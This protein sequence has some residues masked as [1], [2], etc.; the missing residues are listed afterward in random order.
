MLVAQ[1]SIDSPVLAASRSINL[2]LTPQCCKNQRVVSTPRCLQEKRVYHHTFSASQALWSHDSLMIVT[3]G[4][5]DSMPHIEIVAISLIQFKNWYTVPDRIPL[6]G[7]CR[8][9]SNVERRKSGQLVLLCQ[10]SYTIASKFK[11]TQHYIVK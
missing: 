2:K 5:L 3:L 10:S 11:I 8:R 7:P 9:S 1:G 4:S 6:R